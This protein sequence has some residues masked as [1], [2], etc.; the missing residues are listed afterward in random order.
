VQKNIKKILYIFTGG[1]K[2]FYHFINCE[3]PFYD[4]LKVTFVRTNIIRNLGY[5]LFKENGFKYFL[6]KI[7]FNVEKYYSYGAMCLF[8]FSLF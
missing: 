8:L 6:I 4:S 5:S 7:V 1:R 2:F 3:K